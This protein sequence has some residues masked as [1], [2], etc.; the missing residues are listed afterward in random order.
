MNIEKQTYRRYADARAPKSAIV[1]NCI[2][3]FLCGGSI[4]LLGEV[5]VKLY[6]ALGLEKDSASLL[7][8]VTLIFIAILLTALGVFD[9]IAKFAGAGTLVPIT[10]FAN[11]VASPAMDSRAEGP[12]VGVGAKIFTV[13]GPVLL[14]GILAGAVWGVI[15]WVITLV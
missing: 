5:L 14:Y 10:G 1:Q 13:A 7:C 15:Y 9:N 8:S 12:V 6:S 3:A 11:A 2:R 4:C